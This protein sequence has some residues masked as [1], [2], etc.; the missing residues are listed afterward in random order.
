MVLIALSIAEGYNTQHIHVHHITWHPQLINLNFN[1]NDNTNYEASVIWRSVAVWTAHINTIN[2]SLR[3]SMS[4][5]MALI[6]LAAE[7]ILRRVLFCACIKHRCS[8]T[9]MRLLC[10][11]IR[12]VHNHTFTVAF[13]APTGCIRR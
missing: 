5:L 10:K 7:K 2:F 13:L 9:R 11:H 8:Y 12:I 6:R 3:L 1:V 4:R